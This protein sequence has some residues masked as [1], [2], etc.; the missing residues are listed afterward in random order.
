MHGYCHPSGYCQVS[1][2]NQPDVR[3]HSTLSSR[4]GPGPKESGLINFMGWSK[5]QQESLG[6]WD[7]HPDKVGKFLEALLFEFEYVCI[8]L[9]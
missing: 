3:S 7:N 8:I 9:H 6:I 1:L 2:P 5:R 4:E